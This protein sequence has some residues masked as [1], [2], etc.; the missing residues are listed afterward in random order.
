MK[1]GRC[2][3][4]LGA[5][6]L[7]TV[8]ISL[9]LVGVF[10]GCASTPDESGASRAEDTPT[11]VAEPSADWREARLNYVGEQVQ[12]AEAIRELGRAA[13]G[14]A[15]S[16]NGMERRRI[17]SITLSEVSMKDAVTALASKSNSVVQI[18][19]DYY[20]VHPEGYEALHDVSL[21]ESWPKEFDAIE[22]DAVFRTGTP[23]FMV[24]RL[25][26][27]GFNASLV[28]DNAI[29]SADSGEVVL[30]DVPLRSMAE[31]VLKSARVAPGSFGAR[32]GEG[33]LF[34]H[35]ANRVIPP[36]YCSNL[37]EANSAMRRALAKR[38]DIDL[39]KPPLKDGLI[40]IDMGAA[41]LEDVLGALRDQCGIRIR[42]QAGLAGVPVNPISLRGV[43]VQAALDLIIA[44]WL[45]DNVRYAIDGD[46]I[47]IRRV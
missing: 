43:T 32:T 23:L 45:T 11:E 47:L 39:P 14:G 40:D 10:A 2:R 35:A 12:L 7:R 5:C 9:M 36:T 8:L 27:A 34:L 37:E 30:G 33:Y 4:F 24:F 19:S 29:A 20:F 15:V 16:M 18:T 38:V 13:G 26:G 25:L 28:V 31:A 22:G 6:D 41:P 46:S 17:E 1:H 3:A 42:I 21:S 44:Q